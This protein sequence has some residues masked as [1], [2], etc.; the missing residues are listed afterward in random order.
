MFRVVWV[1]LGFIDLSSASTS[2]P[3]LP[4]SLFNFLFLVYL[5]WSL[6]SQLSPFHMGIKPPSATSALADM[7]GHISSLY[8]LELSAVSDFGNSQ[9]TF[10]LFASHSTTLLLDSML[11]FSFSQFQSIFLF[12]WRDD[13]FFLIPF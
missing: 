11:D 13:F 9:D 10:L 4:R 1:C 2:C 12:I 8:K 3:Y 5:S 6:S 7:V